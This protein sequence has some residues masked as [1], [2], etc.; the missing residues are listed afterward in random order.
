MIHVTVRVK[1]K[2]PPKQYS[3]WFV[4]VFRVLTVMRSDNHS[5]LT[6]CSRLSSKNDV[7]THIVDVTYEIWCTPIKNTTHHR[8]NHCFWFLGLFRG[9]PFWHI[10]KHMTEFLVLETRMFLTTL[11]KHVIP[12]HSD[13]T[14][15]C[16]VPYSS[17]SARRKEFKLVRGVHSI[18]L[19][20]IQILG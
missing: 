16:P 15:G 6:C 2:S 8:Q 17:Q 14:P 3:T 12:T 11:R 20:K 19:H 4:R 5:Y 1:R 18:L 7:F 9:T 10:L 13:S